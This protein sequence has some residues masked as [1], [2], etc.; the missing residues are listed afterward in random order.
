MKTLYLR[1]VS[2][3]RVEH[4]KTLKNRQIEPKLLALRA[5]STPST[6]SA[7]FWRPW[8]KATTMIH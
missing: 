1:F 7:T 3:I 4:E 8:R 5:K 6:I 2:E